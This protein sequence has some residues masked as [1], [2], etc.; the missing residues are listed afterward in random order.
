MSSTSENIRNLD[1]ESISIAVEHSLNE[2]TKGLSMELLG[3][4]KKKFETNIHYLIKENLGDITMN[5]VVDSSSVINDLNRF[6]K[7]KSSLLFNLAKNPIFPLCAPPILEK[8]VVDYIENKA[9]K[10]YSK[11]KLREGWK[12]LKPSIT[13]KTI[14]NEEALRVGAQIMKRDPNDVQFVSLI[15]DTGASAIL[16]EDNDFED[17]VRRFTVSTLGDM[18]GVYHRGLFSF[19]IITDLV[20]PVLELAG[21]LVAGVVKILFEII[22]LIATVAKNII[23][24]TVNG[25]S[26]IVSHLPNWATGILVT[27]LVISLI[28]VAVH[29]ETR[30]KIISS[31]K[32]LWKKT[33]PTIDKITSWLAQCV[34]LLLKY[35]KK[36][37]PYIGMS[38][39]AITDLH[40]Q[41]ILLQNEIKNIKLEDAVHYS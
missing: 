25:F 32:S 19:F 12:M 31:L 4:M 9:K 26:R 16:T 39:I 34:K 40:K 11:K 8:E 27:V 20:P 21:K 29:D 13:I 6:A 33:K 22:G 5:I 17:A 3:W 41:I 24:G 10:S 14:Q 7:G 28:V 18:V 23:K 15:I 2:V 30:K 36:S 38:A 37:S 1:Y 35:L